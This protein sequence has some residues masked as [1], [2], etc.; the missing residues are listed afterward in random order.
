MH[1]LI[2]EQNAWIAMAIEDALRE[3]G[4]T[5]F[6]VADCAEEAAALALRRCPDLISSSLRLGTK[7]GIDAVRSICAGRGTRMVF[8]TTTAW[9]VRED[10][11]DVHVVQKPFQPATLKSVVAQAMT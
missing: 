6:D 4:F 3:L 2:I 9:Q 8:V 10:H 5:S 7:Q 1:A 11:P